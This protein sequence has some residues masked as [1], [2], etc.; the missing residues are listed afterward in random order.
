M[1][2]PDRELGA[3]V[4]T[5][6]THVLFVVPRADLSDPARAELI[7]RIKLSPIHAYFLTT[8][9]FDSNLNADP[10]IQALA[11]QS[12][13]LEFVKSEEARRRED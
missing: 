12:A 10:V 11:A 8:D 2:A 5:G 3:A 7:A 1:R 6:I 13:A 9:N 4:G